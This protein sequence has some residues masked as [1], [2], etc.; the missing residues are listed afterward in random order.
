[1][2]RK[3]FWIIVLVLLVLVAGGYY[4]GRKPQQ[5]GRT[6]VRSALGRARLDQFTMTVT[7]AT[8]TLKAGAQQQFLVS[9]SNAQNPGGTWQTDCGTIDQNGM[10]TAPAVTQDTPCKV[11]FVVTQIGLGVDAQISVISP[12]DG[13]A[14]LPTAVMQS[15]QTFMRR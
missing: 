3:H 14:T 5:R 9:E 4:L 11:E 2:K 1:M 8:V 12:V 10:Y 6:Q 13:P 7:P 15:S